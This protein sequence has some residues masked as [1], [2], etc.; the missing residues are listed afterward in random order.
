MLE[1]ST[2]RRPGPPRSPV[3]LADVLRAVAI[4][5]FGGYVFYTG[6]VMYSSAQR[7]ISPI[8]YQGRWVW[9]GLMMAYG[10]Y[11]LIQVLPTTFRKNRSDDD[12]A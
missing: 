11:R 7:I 2:G 3:R 9:G 6:F 4:L 1:P 10:L 5:G 12:N 8:G